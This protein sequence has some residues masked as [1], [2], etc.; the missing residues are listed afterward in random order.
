MEAGEIKDA[1]GEEEAAENDSEY[2]GADAGSPSE[3]LP[4]TGEQRAQG[5]PGLTAPPEGQS[6]EE[7]ELHQTFDGIAGLDH[8]VHHCHDCASEQQDRQKIR[9]CFML[10]SPFCGYLVPL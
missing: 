7:G 5:Y 1:P 6:Q 4:G 9:A 3:P 8:P 2:T 10:F